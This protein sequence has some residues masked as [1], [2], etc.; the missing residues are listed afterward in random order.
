MGNKA[1]RVGA[2][3]AGA[4][5]TTGLLVG[6][7]SYEEKADECYAA[8]EAQYKSGEGFS[9]DPDECKDIKEEDVA[10]MEQGIILEYL[11]NQQ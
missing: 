1:K 9:D 4:A 3:I 6:C 11:L 10:T 8:L 7:Q 5:L 2:L